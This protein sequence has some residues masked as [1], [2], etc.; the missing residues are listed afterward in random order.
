MT[1]LSVGALHARKVNARMHDTNA[2]GGVPADGANAAAENRT[3]ARSRWQPSN[4]TLHHLS[5]CA[6]GGREVPFMLVGERGGGPVPRP[7]T[8]IPRYA[9]FAPNRVT[10][11]L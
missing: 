5:V 11:S 9:M 6:E 7:D 8:A 2:G 10:L 4:I 3:S 1:F